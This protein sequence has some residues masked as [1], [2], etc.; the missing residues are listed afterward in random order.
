[1]FA[2]KDV[3]KL[4]TKIFVKQNK[5]FP[6][7]LEGVDIRIKAKEIYDVGKSQGYKG[8]ISE[9]Q[10]KQF[11]AFEKQ[12]EAAPYRVIPADSPEG[13]IISDKLTGKNVLQFPEGGVDKV[14][15]TKQFTG[16]SFT[17]DDH[18]KFIKSKEPIE[19]MKEANKVIKREGRYKN[20][21]H[22]DADTILKDTEDHIFQRDVP[23]DPQD[24]EGGGIA[25]MLGEPTRRIGLDKGKKV[26]LSKRKFLK[27]A[28]AGLGVLSMLPFVGKFFKPAAKLAKTKTLTSV[29]ITQTGDMPQWFVPLVNKVIKE[30]DDVTKT[31]GEV[32]RQIVHKT[33]LPNSKTDVIVTQDLSTGD[34]AVDIGMGK[35]GF[36]DGHLGQP[37]RLE[38]KAS[39][40]I[41]PTISKPGKVTHKGGK[42]NEEFWVEEAEFTGGHPE[43][44]KFEESSVSK[45]GEHGSDFSEVEKFATGKVTK[46]KPS[47][48]A[49]RAH[50]VPEEDYAAGGIAKLVRAANK[51]APGSTAL[52]KRSKALPKKIKDKREIQKL[53]RD[54]WKKPG[55]VG[56]LLGE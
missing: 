26:D 20:I 13:K 42:T 33:K 6:R 31:F 2:I 32:E 23:M 28:G 44:I 19:S 17:A 30:G 15:V 24:F 35:H 50:W 1:M 25:G 27:G 11:L 53:I 55:G 18:I 52:G 14:S 51:I 5:R 8:D 10:L 46:T 12:R 45:Y 40:V 41:E 47:I 29:P 56:G 22:E 16:Q 7:G 3:I 36:A 38:Y 54:F 37:V 43:N 48:K 49:E 39:E 9:D 21:T 34:V 4:L